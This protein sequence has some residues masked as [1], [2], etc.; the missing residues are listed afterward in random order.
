[1]RI[2]FAAGSDEE[3]A[4]ALESMRQ[5]V[6]A[7]WQECA[8]RITRAGNG[9]A[10][11]GEHERLARALADAALRAAPG[12][13]AELDVLEGGVRRV[14]IAP[15]MDRGGEPL[16]LE[17]VKRAPEVPRV[18]AVRFCPGGSVPPPLADV[19][20]RY[21]VDLS[22]ARVRVGF[23]R[24]HLLEAVVYSPSFSSA[25]DERALGAASL[26]V[27]RLVGEELCHDFLGSV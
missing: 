11:P 14:V 20:S 2:R 24:G 7:F 9:C 3:E 5:R 6:D 25:A 18:R 23:S 1:M 16:A 15:E 19:Q 10:D 27:T 21:A 12:I 26:L 13:R 8:D 22:R 17:F 4:R